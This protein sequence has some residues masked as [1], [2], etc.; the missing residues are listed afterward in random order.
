MREAIGP[1]RLEHPE[2][3]WKVKLMD[4]VTHCSS[5]TEWTAMSGFHIDSIMKKT[6]PNLSHNM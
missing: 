1:E 2:D 4:F 3:T 6:S 5:R